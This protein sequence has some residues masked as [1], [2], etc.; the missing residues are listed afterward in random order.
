MIQSTADPKNSSQPTR[1]VTIAAHEIG[2]DGGQERVTAELISGLLERGCEVTAVA[3]RCDIEP[4]PRLQI[5]AGAWPPAA[6]C[7]AGVAPLHV[8]G[9]L[10]VWRARADF[11]QTAGAAAFNP[12]D[13]ITVHFCNHY[14]QTA[15][16]IKRRSRP[17]LKYRLNES[18]YNLLARAGERWSYRP[19]APISWCRSRLGSPES[20]T[21]SSRLMHDR[22][23][24]YSDGCVD[25]DRFSPIPAPVPRFAGNWAFLMPHSQSYSSAETGSE[26]DC[27]RPSRP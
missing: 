21:S 3:W 20:S 11:R 12:V 26:K 23:T 25:R 18:L 4:H 2:Y 8:L 24:A 27:A 5:S 9:S 17:G 10:Q 6:A 22:I 19:A 14:F 15:I 13:V 7:I 16:G 1:P